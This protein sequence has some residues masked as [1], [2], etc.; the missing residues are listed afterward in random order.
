MLRRQFRYHYFVIAATLLTL[1]LGASSTAY[2]GANCPPYT[3][4]NIETEL[5][6]AINNLTTPTPIK[7]VANPSGR[8]YPENGWDIHIDPTFH[9][10]QIGGSLNLAV[11]TSAVGLY[12]FPIDTVMRKSPAD[13][14]MTFLNWWLI[15][16]SAQ[17][18]ETALPASF[19]ITPTTHPVLFQYK[20]TELFSNI[21]DAPVVTSIIAVRYWAYL[22]GQAQLFRLTQKY[23]RANWALYG[24]AAG[25]GPVWTYDLARKYNPADGTTSPIR[26]ALCNPPKPHPNSSE[27]N[28]CA[29]RRSGG[30]YQYNGHFL[31]LAGARSKLQGQWSSDGKFTLF[32]RAI[33]DVPS[34]LQ[35]YDTN[36]ERRIILDT[37]EQKWPAL[38]STVPQPPPPNENLYGLDRVND[39]PQIKTLIT[40]TDPTESRSKLATLMSWTTFVRTATPYRIMA[41]AG[42]RASMMETNTNFNSPNMYGI[43]YIQQPDSSDPSHAKAVF[44]HPWTDAK[45]GGAD[46]WCKF[47]GITGGMM[48]IHASNA[49]SNPGPDRKQPPGQPIR[50]V[51]MSLPGEQPLFDVVLSPERPPEQ[52]FSWPPLPKIFV[53]STFTPG[54]N[55]TSWVFNQMIPAGAVTGGNLEDWNWIDLNPE[56]Q[57]DAAFVHQSS[58]VAGM[59]QHY[60]Y[61]ATDTLTVNPG[62]RL[63][64]WVYLDPVNPPS[65]VMLQWFEPGTG[66]EHRAYWG[67][68]NL[69]FG[70]DGTV[71]R[72]YMG[73]L[74][75]LDQ[76]VLLEVPA[77]MVG[78]EGLT[79]NGMAFSLFNGVAT[80]DDAGKSNQG[81]PASNLS[82]GK[83]ATQSSTYTAAP[84][85]GPARLAV[86]GN[87][88]ASYYGNSVS[89]TN[90]DYQAWWQ[91]D[92]GTSYT[93]DQV[94]IWNRTDCCSDRLSNFYVLVSD[95]PFTST[96]LATTLNQPGVLSFYVAGI[97]GSPSAIPIVRSGR[98]VRVQLAGTNYLGLAEVQVMGHLPPPLPPAYEGFHDSVDCGYIS[99]WVWNKNNPGTRVNVSVY[100]DVTGAL[101]TTGTADQFRQ[102]LLNAGKG[103]GRYGFFIPTPAFYKDG[104][105][106]TFR[107]R[108][109]N[110][111]IR[112]GNTPRTFTCVPPSISIGFV[113]PAENSWGD[114]NTMT[115]AGYA[116][117][118]TGGV[119][120]VW[121]DETLGTTWNPVA[122][123]PYPG[124]DTTWSNTIPS[125]YKCHTFRVYANYSGV[126]SADFVYNGLTAGFCSESAKITSIQPQSGT[127]V[128]VGTAANAP[129]GTL[130]FMKYRDLT[131]DTTWVNAPYAPPPDAN[132]VWVNEVR[133]PNGGPV[134]PFHKY[135]VQIIYDVKASACIYQGNNSTSWCP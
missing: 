123:Q 38:Q 34:P 44:M 86:D 84:P 48:R 112:L 98:Y 104:R 107:V 43:A 94:N 82:L 21:Y 11:V 2:G 125:P 12:R 120:L 111:P 75:P 99:G 55:T 67:A 103:D 89:H 119:Q 117:N 122:Y 59:H 88:N 51:V 129:D 15:Y 91:V 77:N 110:T 53:P 63:Y 83:P 100:D 118:G 114:P 27:Y 20:G 31:A 16:L 28:M 10:W 42:W 87:T 131:A 68:N 57:S 134:N 90:Y 71:S 135:D 22:N 25:M 41:W 1:H 96:D 13:Q 76:W 66:W 14:P 92:L 62:D 64:A 61:Y 126:R 72:R 30:G 130:V 116:Q 132:H 95:D 105:S 50:E 35:S 93:L 58:N 32:D 102:D 23:L 56:P 97:A 60:F 74:P 78:A 73:P 109:T 37:L 7:C 18:G 52:D 5:V 54:D 85:G 49:L 81:G 3:P 106:H 36:T 29:P 45:S 108:V 128:V 46:G 24:M 124:A 40:S 69:S 133:G 80:W 113:K 101:V 9:S 19:N 8:A 17:V 79:L 65:E 33:E 70:T 39:I 26:T 115:A 127:L 121:R 4:Q 6:R 47:D